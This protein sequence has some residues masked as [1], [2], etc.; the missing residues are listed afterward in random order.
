MKVRKLTWHLLLI[1]IHRH[2]T[3]S[4]YY[5][6]HEMCEFIFSERKVNSSEEGAF[7]IILKCAN[8]GNR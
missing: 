3:E 4:V 1:A 8:L 2:T 6:A 5:I 7:H